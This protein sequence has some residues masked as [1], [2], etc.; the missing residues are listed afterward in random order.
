MSEA[1]SIW[2]QDFTKCCWIEILCVTVGGWWVPIFH[3]CETPS[4][5]R[6]LAPITK[7]RVNITFPGGSE[8]FLLMTQWYS[9]QKDV[10]AVTSK[11]RTRSLILKRRMIAANPLSWLFIS[12]LADQASHVAGHDLVIIWMSGTRPMSTS[13]LRL[14]ALIT[15]S[16][17]RPKY[18]LRT[19]NT[20]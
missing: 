2:M 16:Q 17:S 12:P 1:L 20:K 18:Y 4:L 13:G 6:V 14:P 19:K 9:P 3:S 10:N 15:G 11:P 7:T 8:T 5:I